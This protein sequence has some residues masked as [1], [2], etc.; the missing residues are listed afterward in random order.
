MVLRNSPC[1]VDQSECA[2]RKAAFV[3]DGKHAF[4]NSQLGCW[5]CAYI[6]GS[7]KRLPS[8]KDFVGEAKLEN[9]PQRVQ[10]SGAFIKQRRFKASL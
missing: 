1:F 5:L 6:Y 10:Y 8:D 3:F 9:I 2:S 4:G 7:V